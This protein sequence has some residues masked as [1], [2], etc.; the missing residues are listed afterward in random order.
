MEYVCM[1]RVLSRMSATYFENGVVSTI[2]CQSRRLGKW[3]VVV[4]DPDSCREFLSAQWWRIADLGRINIRY[5]EIITNRSQVH[6]EVTALDSGISIR[7]TLRVFIWHWFRFSAEV[8]SY[9]AGECF[10]K[11]YVA[12]RNE[13]ELEQQTTTY[14]CRNSSSFRKWMGFRM[15]NAHWILFGRI[16]EFRLIASSNIENITALI[17]LP[18]LS[19]PGNAPCEAL[20]EMVSAVL[21]QVKIIFRQMSRF[22]WRK[23][24]E[25]PLLWNV[26]SLSN[27]DRE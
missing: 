17:W 12:S 3:K 21:P 23:D 25:S 10:I 19:I 8:T 14:S 16:A 2:L 18:L 11:V 6:G 27:Y 1:V 15:K 9:R 13:I 24:L 26:L 4:T 22:S 20:S 7:T 5:D